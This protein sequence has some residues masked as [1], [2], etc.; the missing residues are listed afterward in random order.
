MSAEAL[1][2]NNPQHKKLPSIADEFQHAIDELDATAQEIVK[3]GSELLP[4]THHEP[5]YSGP[6]GISTGTT[7]SS[8]EIWYGDEPSFDSLDQSSNH[9]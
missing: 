4:N 7:S 5:E 8:E 3:V 6:H 2:T 1:N 9:F